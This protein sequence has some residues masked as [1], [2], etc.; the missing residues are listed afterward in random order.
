MFSY[1]LTTFVEGLNILVEPDEK[2]ETARQ[3]LNHFVNV[4]REIQHLVDDLACSIYPPQDK[5]KLLENAQSLVEQVQSLLHLC[6]KCESFEINN[7]DKLL[8]LTTNLTK[9]ALQQL[10]NLCDK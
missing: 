3:E 9:P 4:A 5:P 7:I 8:S 1:E 2:Q 6:T 10:E